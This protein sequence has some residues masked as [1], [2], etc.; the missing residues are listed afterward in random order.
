MAPAVIRPSGTNDLTTPQAATQPSVITGII[1]TTPDPGR[2]KAT[3]TDLALGSGPGLDYTLVVAPATQIGPRT[4]VTCLIRISPM[5]LDF[6][7]FPTYL[8]AFC[9]SSF[10]R[11]VVEES[12]GLVLVFYF[13][14]PHISGVLILSA[15][16]SGKSSGPVGCLFTP[17]T[18]FFALQKPFHFVSSHLPTW[19]LCPVLLASSAENP[20]LYLILKSFPCSLLAVSEF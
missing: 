19:R 15:V 9:V 2:C 18:V 16:G 4:L 20:R 11:I 8:L 3:D 14:G 12:R 10:L 1:D 17:A 6:A 13:E 7:H 5:T